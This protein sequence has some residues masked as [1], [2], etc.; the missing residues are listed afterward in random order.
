MVVTVLAVFFLGQVV[1]GESGD[2]QGTGIAVAVVIAAL[3]YFLAHLHHDR[4]RGGRPRG[5]RPG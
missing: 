1:G 4:S 5:G 2:L 3:T